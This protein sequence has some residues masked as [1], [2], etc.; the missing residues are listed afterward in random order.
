MLRVER[1]GRVAVLTI[2]R[3]D[4]RNAMDAALVAALGKQLVELDHAPEIGAIV[5]DGVSPGFC[6]GSDLKF[7]GRLGLRDMCRFEA[8]TGAMA[9]QIGLIDK[10][11]IA[12]V[13]GFA[14][15]GGFILAASCDVVVTATSARW[16][17]PEVPIG[18]L[19][20][21]GLGALVARVGPVRARLL[22]WALAPFDGTEAERLGVA[23]HV[24]PPGTARDTAIALAQKLSALPAPAMIATKRFFAPL[25]IKDGEA[26]DAEANRLFAENCAH[27]AAQATLARYGA[28]S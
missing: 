20:P 26:L 21:W 18:W 28:M 25:M 9:R 19:T 5:L 17:L 24:A 13:E 10:P 7:I 12:A 11:V 14:I 4:R 3:M 1:E 6:A 15:G 22:C 27:G 16:H 2:A 23:D 8:D